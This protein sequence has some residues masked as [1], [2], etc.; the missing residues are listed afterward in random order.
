MSPALRALWLP[1]ALALST[2]SCCRAQQQERQQGAPEASA[3]SPPPEAPKPKPSRCVEPG[4]GEVVTLGNDQPTDEGDPLPFAVEIGDGVV[5]AHGFAAGALVPDGKRG[6]NAA[7]VTLDERGKNARTITLAA[8]HGDTQPPRLAADGDAIV[9]ALLDSSAAGRRLR[10][11]R[12]EQS[13]ITWGPAFDQGRDESLAFDVAVSGSRAMAV[14]DDDAKDPERGAIYAVTFDASL[15]GKPGPTTT[16]SG[17]KTD[18]EMPRVMARPSG[19]W[20]S[21]IGRVPEKTDDDAR[22]VGES[23]EF[24]YIEVVPIDEAGQRTGDA[25]RVTPDRGHV[26]TY[27]AETLADGSLLL[28][29]RDDDTPSGSSG[30]IVHSVHVRA[31]GSGDPELIADRGLGAASPTLLPGYLAMA[32][33]TDET[34]LARL[35]PDGKLDGALVS[36]PVLGRGEP[37]AARGDTLLVVKPRGLAVSLFVTTCSAR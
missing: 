32:D 6:A 24:R 3:G 30:G 33:A 12:L 34:R 4:P 5:T 2:A 7:V 35:T 14:W 10:T 11:A 19:F 31:G 21:W 16:L 27:D 15:H 36:E 26:L 1:F 29:Y 22:E 9:A 37:L 28:V 8:A 13:N 18:A 20:V 17:R 23:P 25:R